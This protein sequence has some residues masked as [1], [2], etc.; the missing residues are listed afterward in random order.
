M[1]LEKS[2]DRFE[3]TRVF[4]EHP[5]SIDVDEF[6]PY[7]IGVA[8][9]DERGDHTGTTANP[10]QVLSVNAEVMDAI[11]I[12]LRILNRYAAEFHGIEI[13]EEDVL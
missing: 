12:Q 7:S 10:V 6:D 2:T 9:V 11:L 1:P 8:L 4:R 13:T 5:E 3:T